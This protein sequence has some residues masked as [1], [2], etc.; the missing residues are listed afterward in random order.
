MTLT[1]GGGLTERSEVLTYSDVQKY[2][3]R[4]RKSGHK[5]RYFAV[6]EYGSK[7]GR[8]HWHLILFY[9]DTPPEMPMDE[10]VNEKHWPH[11]FS[12][13]EIA[14]NAS[15]RYCV[16]YLYKDAGADESKQAKFVLSKLPA[17]G[18]PYFQKLAY[19]Y[20]Q[21]GIAPREMFYWFPDVLNSKTGLPERFY[22]SKHS[23]AGI[24]FLSSFIDA[25]ASI[26][27][28]DRWPHSDLVEEFIDRNTVLTE[29]LQFKPIRRGAKPSAPPP[30]GSPP[31]FSESHNCYYSDTIA[32]RL[33]FYLNPQGDLV[34]H[35]KI[36]KNGSAVSNGRIAL[37]GILRDAPYLARPQDAL[38]SGRGVTK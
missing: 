12:Q 20:A 3:K 21:Q 7:K 13:W 25:W 30:G 29:P 19:D 8:C 38:R 31:L 28:N 9:Q 15:M 36:G 32:G 22:L 24:T 2:L 23:A 33:W 35:T 10:R 34:W 1:Y 26:H 37:G 17:I 18:V 14:S 11:G 6:G 4:L 5:F 16:K 27:G